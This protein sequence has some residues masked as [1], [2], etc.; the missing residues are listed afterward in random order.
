MGSAG[1]LARLPQRGPWNPLCYPTLL[2]VTQSHHLNLCYSRGYPN[3]IKTISCPLT[4]SGVG[5]ESHDISYGPGGVR[6][7]VKASIGLG[8]NGDILLKDDLPC[9]YSQITQILRY[10]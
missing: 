6:F 4:R 10:W 8:Y 7:C 5:M 3:S 9:T 2:L 1:N